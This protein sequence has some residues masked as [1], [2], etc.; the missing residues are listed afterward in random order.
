MSRFYK[1]LVCCR[2]VVLTWVLVSIPTIRDVGAQ[3]PNGDGEADRWRRHVAQVEPELGPA[4]GGREPSAFIAPRDQWREDIRQRRRAVNQADVEAWRKVE[5]REAWERFSE[6]RLAALRASLGAWPAAPPQIASQVTRKRSGDGFTIEC[7]I[8]ESR[9]GFWV[10]ANLYVPEPPRRLMPGLLICHSHHHPK[11]QGELQ[12]MGMTWARQ[13]CLVLIPDQVGHGERRQHPY[14]T[15]ADWPDPF[16]VGRQDYYF[17]YVT[18]MQ[19]HLVGESLIGWMVWDMMRGMDMLLGRPGVDPQRMI[20]LGAVA[21]GGDPTAVTAALDQRIRGAVPFNFGGPQPESVYPLPDDAEQSFNYVGGGS[22]ESTRN[23]RLSARDGFLPWVIVGSLAPRML[24]YAHEFSWDR[25]RDPVWKRFETIYDWYDARDR[26]ASTNGWG[27]VTLSSAEASH[28]NNIGA[29]HRK[30]I[31]SAFERWFGIRTPDPEYQERLESRELLC[32]DDASDVAQSRLMPV[33]RLADQLARERLAA[34]RESRQPLTAADRLARM[35]AE[36]ETRLGLGQVPVQPK[37]TLAPSSSETNGRLRELR[38]WVTSE[39]ALTVP[40]IVLLPEKTDA[41]RVPVVVY[42]AQEGKAAVLKNRR[43]E[44]ASLL[45]QNMAVCLPDL[46]G[47]GEM[48]PDEGRGRNS[49]ATSYSASEQMLGSTALGGKL[50]DLLAVVRWLRT[51]DELQGD[52]IGVRGD[53]F[54]PVNNADDRLDSPFNV[55]PMPQQAEP[56]GALLA[57][58]AALFDEKI[59][60]ISGSGGL[61]SQRSVLDHPYVYLPHDAIVPGA[62]TAGDISDI[63][64]VVAPRPVRLDRM[65]TGVN[66]LATSDEMASEWPVERRGPGLTLAA[67]SNDWLTWLV[68]ALH[69]KGSGTASADQP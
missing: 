47:C 51:R 23:L 17:R 36:W 9:P 18:G 49:S 39:R 14:R 16:Q 26:L 69:E 11:T 33:H 25:D 65:V 1:G 43:D 38:G 54:A 13:G 28:C 27:R 50:A 12:D 66:R 60:A 2:W 21:G 30:S 32:L 19:L 35:R 62:L 37:F 20:I 3:E 42:V 53:S 64:A 4:P 24:I 44:V 48:S 59:A 22:F 45:E 7:L 6:P 52:R 40:V 41:K 63:A 15:A 34:Q 10:T 31:H 8:F 29:P 67:S 46:R 61:V 68:G 58:L 57:L 56:A 5:S 55:T